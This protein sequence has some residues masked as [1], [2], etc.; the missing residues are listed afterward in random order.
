MGDERWLKR[1]D[2]V[3]SYFRE[4]EAIQYGFKK[5]ESKDGKLVIPIAFY[6]DWIAYICIW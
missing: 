5:A 3:V 6:D 4:V 1:R 2:K